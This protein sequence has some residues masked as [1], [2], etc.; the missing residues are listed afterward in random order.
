M[1]TSKNS[2]EINEQ[3]YSNY[4]DIDYTKNNNSK[5]STDKEL[6]NETKRQLSLDSQAKTTQ[7]KTKQPKVFQEQS[8]QTEP[9]QIEIPN[10][11]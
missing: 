6:A 1:I 8:Y 5:D 4:L 9:M 3:F 2:K 11:N 7:E 10:I